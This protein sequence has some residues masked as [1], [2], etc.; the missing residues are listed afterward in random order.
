MRSC[1]NFPEM[2]PGVSC[3]AQR[4][5]MDLRRKLEGPSACVLHHAKPGN[6]TAAGFCRPRIQT[7]HR[8]APC[9]LHRPAS[10]KATA[11]V[12]RCVKFCHHGHACTP[13]HRHSRT[14]LACLGLL[15]LCQFRPA[16]ASVSVFTAA[17]TAA[18]P[19]LP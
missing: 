6:Y 8:A 1:E 17:P 15:K 13:A 14:F 10:T 4:A 16:S 5:L 11:S 2:R 12:T 9:N 7:E 19:S 18:Q 3:G